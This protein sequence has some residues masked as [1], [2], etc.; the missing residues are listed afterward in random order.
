M[1]NEQEKTKISIFFSTLYWKMT[2]H[3]YNKSVALVKSLE[4]IK[5]EKTI[6][7]KE[8]PIL[9]FKTYLVM[10]GIKLSLLFSNNF[11]NIAKKLR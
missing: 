1:K 7:K 8:I 5:S 4:S 11:L 6:T 10:M 9:I 2:V 3:Q